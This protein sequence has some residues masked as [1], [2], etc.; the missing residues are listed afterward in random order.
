MEDFDRALFTAL[1]AKN[2]EDKATREAIFDLLKFAQQHALKVV[3][4]TNNNSFHYVVGTPGGSAKLFYCYSEGSVGMALGNFPHLSTA[5]VSR[6]TRVLGA[7][8]PAFAYILRFKDR[9]KKGGM[10]LFSI[11]QTLVDPTVMRGFK[12]AVRKLQGEIDPSR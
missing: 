11:A 3:G 4:G 1:V 7:L 8:S 6:F 5:A 12:A 10:Q 9:R 2:V